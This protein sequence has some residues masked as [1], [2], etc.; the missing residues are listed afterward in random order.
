M[1]MKQ[2][3]VAAGNI[4]LNKK[5]SRNNHQNLGMGGPGT[6]GTLL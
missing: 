1:A 6:A 3:L 4:G 2:Q 5:Y